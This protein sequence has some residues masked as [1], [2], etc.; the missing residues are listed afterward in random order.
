MTCSAGK[1]RF[2]AR[3]PMKINIPRSLVFAA[4][5]GLFLLLF[6]IAVPR[7]VRA[8]EKP[9]ASSPSSKLAQDLTGVWVHVGAPGT[10]GEPPA[11]GGRL[12]FR[13]GRHWT[14][15]GVDSRSS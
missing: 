1:F 8:A 11:K 15:V 13:T 6:A 7:S 3:T 9:A 10:I 12:K 2:E 14:L 5:G 4:A